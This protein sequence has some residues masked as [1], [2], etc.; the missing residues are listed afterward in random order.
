M[1][2]AAIIGISF[3][4]LSDLK[5]RGEINAVLPQDSSEE[6]GNEQTAP[7][8]EDFEKIY[9]RELT[10]ALEQIAGVSNVTVVVTIEA[11]ERKVFEKNTA[12]KTQETKEQDKKGGERT[13]TDQTRDENL[14]MV[15]KDGGEAPVIQEMKK[16]DIRGVLVVAE[17]AENIQV[18]KW[19]IE[20]VTRVLNVPSHRVAVMPKKPKEDA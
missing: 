12:V 3:M 5:D 6:E 1:A 17:G 2:I 8:K 7:A 13:I 9:E 4:L 15:K 10:A 14:V 16:P 20:S 11:S 18:K 19:I